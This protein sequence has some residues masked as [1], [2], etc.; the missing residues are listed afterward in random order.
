[1]TVSGDPDG[2]VEIVWTATAPGADVLYRWTAALD[3]GMESLDFVI[4]TDNT[5]TVVTMLELDDALAAA[6]VAIGESATLYH[7]V[8][9]AVDTVETVGPV[10]SVTLLR[11]P[12]TISEHEALAGGF[13]IESVY[14]NPSKSAPTLQ[15]SVPRPSEVEVTV[16][17]VLGRSVLSVTRMLDQNQTLNLATLVPSLPAGIYLVR[18]DN[19]HDRERTSARFTIVP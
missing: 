6:G 12:P 18:L 10:S 13:R 15:L 14:P 3:A 8:H 9:A 11:Q 2:V 5:N 7:R 17:D 1:M 19:L 16:F 4:E